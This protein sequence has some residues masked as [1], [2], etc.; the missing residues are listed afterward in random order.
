MLDAGHCLS[1]CEACNVSGAGLLIDYHYDTSLLPKL[2][3]ESGCGNSS[4]NNN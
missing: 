1:F 2:D 3:T 4:A